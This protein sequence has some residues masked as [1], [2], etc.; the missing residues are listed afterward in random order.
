MKVLILMVI[1]DCPY[2]KKMDTDVLRSNGAAGG[3]FLPS[4]LGK[5]SLHCT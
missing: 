4:S 2:F 5:S 1:G 3:N